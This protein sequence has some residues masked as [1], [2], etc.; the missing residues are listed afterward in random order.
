[1]LAEMNSGLILL[2]LILIF[3]AIALVVYLI[4]RFVPAFKDTTEKPKSEEE[5]AKEKLDSILVPMDEEVV[6]EKKEESK[7]EEHKE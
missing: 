1:M 5:A 6:E 3:G 2:I 7:E 4:R